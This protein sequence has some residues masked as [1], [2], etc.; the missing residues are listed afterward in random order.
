MP[1]RRREIFVKRKKEGKSVREIAI[2]MNIS[3][4]TVENQ[5][6]EA[7]NYLKKEFDNDRIS[8]MLFFYVF[9]D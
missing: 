6:T 3:L 1:D 4:K 5:I 9:V 8:G 7:M 2:E